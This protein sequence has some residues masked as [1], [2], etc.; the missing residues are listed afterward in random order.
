VYTTF[1][2]LKEQ[3]TYPN[4]C[5]DC[6]E[7]QL[8]EALQ[9]AQIE[10]LYNYA[11]YDWNFICNWAECLSPGERQRLSFSRLFFKKT[12]K[13]AIL[14]ESTSALDLDTEEKIYRTLRHMDV[15][16]ISVGHRDT[17]RKFHDYELRLDGSTGY[18]VQAITL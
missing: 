15:T 9:L 13:F 16:V 14:D 1:G 17:L 11:G 6:D 4:E 8:L 2:S 10:H 18:S 12:C 3:I 5:T 7:T